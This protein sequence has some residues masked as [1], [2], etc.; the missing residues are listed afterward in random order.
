MFYIFLEISLIGLILSVLMATVYFYKRFSLS[1]DLPFYPINKLKNSMLTIGIIGDSWANGEKLNPYLHN[2]L[3][4]QE[5]PNKIISSGHSG[6]KTKVI[7][8]NLFKNEDEKYSS[9]FIVENSPDFCIVLAGTNDAITQ[10]GPNY[11]SSHLIKIIK[12]LLHYN[13]MPVV[14]TVPRVGIQT[15]HKHTTLIKKC[16]NLLSVLLNNKCSIENIDSYRKKLM[17]KLEIEELKNSILVIDFDKACEKYK[18]D[19]DL[20]LNS[21][22]LSNKGHKKL[23]EFVGKEI[24]SNLNSKSISIHNFN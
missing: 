10:M 9:K 1:K 21:S 3:L 24:I 19:S 12:L 5:L 14:V 17:E 6:A 8:Q 20:Y 18:K 22:H 15:L 16:R 23:A 11:Y 13:I 2:Y 4:E 7:Y